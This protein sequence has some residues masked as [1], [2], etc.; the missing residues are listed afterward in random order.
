MRSQAKYNEGCT[1]KKTR[2]S[3]LQNQREDPKVLDEY[4]DS[5][6]SNLYVDERLNMY[7]QTW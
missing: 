2:S 5:K 4:S 3:Q 7:L 1:Y 6:T